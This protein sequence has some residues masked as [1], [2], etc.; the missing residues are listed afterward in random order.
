M[1]ISTST[2]ERKIFCFLVLV[3][4]LISRM[5]TLGFSCACACTYFTIVNHAL[6]RQTRQQ[7]AERPTGLQGVREANF[8]NEQLKRKTKQKGKETELSVED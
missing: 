3:L 5:F 6:D 2:R 4:V 8:N 1:S 7:F